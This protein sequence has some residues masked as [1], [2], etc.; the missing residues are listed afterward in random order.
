MAAVRTDWGAFTV[1][2][3]VPME[4]DHDAAIEPGFLTSPVPSGDSNP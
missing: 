1:S 2:V 4:E 3:T